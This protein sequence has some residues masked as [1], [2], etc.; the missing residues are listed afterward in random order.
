MG[1]SKLYQSGTF[2]VFQEGT[3][4]GNGTKFLWPSAVTPHLFFS[5]ATNG[6]SW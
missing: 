6:K 3:L 4:E 5:P 2:G 1:V